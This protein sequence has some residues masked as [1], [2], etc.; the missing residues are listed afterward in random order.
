TANYSFPASTDRALVANFVF[1]PP[2]V[3]TPMFS[4]NGGTFMRKVKVRIFCPTPGATIHYTT[5][6]TDPTSASPVFQSTGKRT[7]NTGILV[8]GQGLHTVKAIAIAT[9]FNNSAI[10]VGIFPTNSQAV[11][12]TA[13]V[14]CS[15]RGAKAAP[16][17]GQSRAK[18]RQKFAT[19]L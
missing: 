14:K 11:A 3:A 2:T 8:T 16:T 7:K 5:D 19:E 17:L 10:A 1:A 9:G 18:R 4:P 15:Y 12:K 6:G 13:P